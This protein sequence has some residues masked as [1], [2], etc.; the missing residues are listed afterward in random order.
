M[1]HM[2]TSISFNL[3]REEATKT[4]ELAHT[5]G[6]ATTS[7]YLRFLLSQDDVDLITEDE[8]TARA[9]QVNR[10][11]KKGKLIKAKTLADLLN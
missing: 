5:R 11:H 10:L 2:R 3:T 4:K 7:D 1:H 6:F 8:L 9:K